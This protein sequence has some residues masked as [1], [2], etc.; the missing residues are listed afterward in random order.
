VTN[1]IIS[2]D[3]PLTSIRVS[4]AK[5]L[6]RITG[7]TAW[8]PIAIPSHAMTEVDMRFNPALPALAAGA[9]GIGVTEFAPMGM[10]PSIAADLGFSIPV[11]GLLVG[12][13]MAGAALAMLYRL[14]WP[15]VSPVGAGQQALPTIGP[16]HP[17]NGGPW[18]RPDRLHHRR[19]ART[20]LR[21]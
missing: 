14:P 4:I 8:P 2:P 9:F 7:Y 10:L 12:A 13:A 3:H 18:Q 17:A 6:A 19:F 11:A 15:I 5:L 1:T 21:Q 20:A 16:E